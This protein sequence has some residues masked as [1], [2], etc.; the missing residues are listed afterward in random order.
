MAWFLDTLESVEIYITCSLFH[1]QRICI[2]LNI[3]AKYNN[4]IVCVLNK[5]HTYILQSFFL[6]L[7][8]E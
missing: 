4:V 6:L 7:S 5:E 1:M 2:T 3:S 8:L